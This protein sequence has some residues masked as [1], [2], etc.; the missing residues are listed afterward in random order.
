MKTRRNQIFTDSINRFNGS[1]YQIGD[2]NNNWLNVQRIERKYETTSQ[3]DISQFWN[4]DIQDWKNSEMSIYKFDDIGNPVEKLYFY[5]ESNNNKWKKESR[6]IY[7]WSPEAINANHI[8][9][10]D[11][12]ILYPNP[13]S[14]YI[15]I[16]N[17][18]NSVSDFII[19]NH[20]GFKV[21]TGIIDKDKTL[22][23]NIN[24]LISGFYILQIPDIGF[25]SKKIIITN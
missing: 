3:T 14:D 18:S 8:T 13:T 5:W 25:F 24:D 20:N 10:N 21:K 7:F 12:I 2:E 22:K 6:I 17:L 1:L 15:S 4:K 9:R 23:I 19:F 11:E 16:E